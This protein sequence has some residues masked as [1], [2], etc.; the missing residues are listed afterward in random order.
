MPPSI[1]RQLP[2]TNADSSAAR[3]S[4]EAAISSG[5]PMRFSNWVEAISSYAFFG[6]G[7]SFS[8]AC[9]NGVSTRPGQIALNRTF[10][11]A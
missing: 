9:T 1:T 11:S 5:R 3:K 8:R 4:A 6:S 2:V 7:Y 10:E